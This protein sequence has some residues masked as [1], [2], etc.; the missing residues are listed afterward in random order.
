MP[1]VSAA[2]VAIRSSIL[3]RVAIVF[4]LSSIAELS[5][6]DRLLHRFAAPF[7]PAVARSEWQCRRRRLIWP[8]ITATNR[9][10]L[11]PT[12]TRTPHNSVRYVAG[13]CN[14]SAPPPGAPPNSVPKNDI[15]KPGTNGRASADPCG[16][17]PSAPNP[18]HPPPQ[19]NKTP[20]PH[21]LLETDRPSIVPLLFRAGSTPPPTAVLPGETPLSPLP[22]VPCG[23]PVS[24]P[25]TGVLTPQ[26]AR[27]AT[28][29]GV[30][31]PTPP[32]TQLRNASTRTRPRPG[33]P[34]QRRAW[35]GSPAAIA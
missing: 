10:S 9:A 28:K 30:P 35:S 2:A 22:A 21:H 26:S 34:H 12:K 24:V 6:S 19:N 20:A 25:A 13:Y 27:N 32:F 31:L 4:R 7:A 11:P 29:A 3:H 23:H 17:T 15:N 16:R 18:Q 5:S 14:L 33:A 1:E 8:G